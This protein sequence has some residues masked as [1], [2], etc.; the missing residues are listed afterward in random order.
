MPYVLRR[1]IRR[2]GRRWR[3]HG[4]S[5]VGRNDAN[6]TTSTPFPALILRQRLG[7]LDLA[8][9][10]LRLSLTFRC[11]LRTDNEQLQRQN[12]ELQAAFKKQMQLIA[13]LKRQKIHLASAKA[14]ASSE[15]QFERI[16]SQD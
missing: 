6:L 1:R 10:D 2:R 3:S 11:W 14:L 5:E 4:C 8:H 7:T 13:V 9:P 15:E 16:L 12:A